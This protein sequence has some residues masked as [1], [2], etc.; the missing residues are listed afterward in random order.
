VPDRWRC[1]CKRFFAGPRALLLPIFGN[2]SVRMKMGAYNLYD[3]GES[4]IARDPSV[5]CEASHSLRTRERQS[6]VPTV[7]IGGWPGFR[8]VPSRV[9]KARVLLR[10]KPQEHPACRFR[11]RARASAGSLSCPKPHLAWPA[12]GS[13]PALNHSFLGSAVLRSASRN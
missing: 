6:Y 7:C 9:R 8:F 13:C 12:F 5:G 3:Y 10:R 4:S 2:Q 1:D 11:S